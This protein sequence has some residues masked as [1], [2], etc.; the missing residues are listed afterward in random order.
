MKR[1]PDGSGV[2]TFSYTHSDIGQGLQDAGFLE[3]GG[4]LYPGAF[5]CATQLGSKLRNCALG[6]HYMECDDADA[7]HRY[8]QT[9][10]TNPL[11]QTVLEELAG[12][13]TY[14]KRLAEH[15]FGDEARTKPIKTLLHMM[16]ND[17][18]C[19]DWRR[20]HKIPKSIPDHP[21]VE[22]FGKAMETITEELASRGH[23]PEALALASVLPV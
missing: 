6:A 12:D 11:V 21:L 9:L 3:K 8:L 17:G 2:C 14:R 22:R 5:P 13:K 7:F 19:K 20:E 4:Q 23:G 18:L 10:S 15:Y 16:A 1:L